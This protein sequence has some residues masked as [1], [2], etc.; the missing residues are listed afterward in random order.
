MEVVNPLK[1]TILMGT[2][3]VGLPT[4]D[5]YTDIALSARLYSSTVT[6]D[7]YLNGTL[8]TTEVSHP[9]FASSLL[10]PFIINYML[11]WYAWVHTEW[12]K[13]S[14]KFTWI[15]A[16]LGCYPQLLACGIIWLFWTKPKRAEREKTHLERNVM[17]N[18]VYTE[19]V[20]TSFMMLSLAAVTNVG[21]EDR[22]LFHGDETLFG[23]ATLTSLLS[24]S[25]GLAKCLKVG[26]TIVIRLSL[27]LLK[28]FVKLDQGRIVGQG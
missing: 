12:N 4:V 13:E 19:A 18:E 28:D 11:G 17:Q 26:L 8:V 15:F 24:A 3:N 20:P 21:S 14:K 5:V 22:E 16:I 27:S 23:Y 9:I 10:F 6:H 25:L 1:E 7:P 2:L